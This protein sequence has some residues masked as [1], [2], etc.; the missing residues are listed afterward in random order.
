MKPDHRGFTIIEMM[1]V[2]AIIGILALMAAPTYQD[3]IVRDEIV[4]ALPL[5]DLAKTR[6]AATWSMIQTLPRDNQEAGLPP[7]EK[8]VSNHIRATLV[9]D[10]A[11]HITFGN[12]ANAL[13]AGKTLSL[14]PAVVTDAPVVPIAW[15]CGNAAVPGKMTARGENRTDIPAKF[16]PFNCRARSTGR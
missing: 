8:I 11:I 4:A 14:R 15:V 13:I 10:G 1:I 7:A 5:A 2:L 16:L 9:R 6:I 3:K 12:N